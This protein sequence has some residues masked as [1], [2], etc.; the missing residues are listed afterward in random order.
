MVPTKTKLTLLRNLVI[1]HFQYR[2]ISLSGI[3]KSLPTTL[4]KQLNWG[5][6]SLFQYKKYD[7]S[8]D[9][10]INYKILPVEYLIRYRRV[11]YFWEIINKEIPAFQNTNLETWKKCTNFNTIVQHQT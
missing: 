5:V 8:S 11:A 3:I 10:K 6:K 1:S 9:L 2:A 7:S 4:E